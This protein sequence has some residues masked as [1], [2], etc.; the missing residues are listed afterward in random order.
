M[1]EKLYE[2]F[3]LYNAI[4]SN[5][6]FGDNPRN[7]YRVNWLELIVVH[8]D[9]R[10]KGVARAFEPKIVSVAK[11]QGCVLAFGEAADYRSQLFAKKAGFA[12]LKELRPEDVIL[13]DGKPLGT[14]EP[15]MASF[16]IE[17][18]FID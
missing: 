5:K 15:P 1:C 9:F 14:F 2:G 16:S 18:K 7:S 4:N 12:T 8:T 11:E 3:N 13:K 10:R 17:A 6:K